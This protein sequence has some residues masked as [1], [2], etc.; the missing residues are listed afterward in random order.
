MTCMNKYLKTN[1][2]HV[3]FRNIFFYYEFFKKSCLLFKIND[4]YID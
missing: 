4:K 3:I 1:Y 2:G